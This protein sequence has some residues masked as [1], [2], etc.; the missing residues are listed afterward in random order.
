MKTP[1]WVPKLDPSETV[2]GAACAY[3]EAGWFVL[4]VDRG[5]KHAGSV[6]GRGWPEKSSRDSAVVRGWF[7]GT[8]YGV[9][10]HAGRSGCLAFDVDDPSALPPTLGEHLVAHTG[11]YQSTR[12]GSASR[13][14][15]LYLQPESRVHGNGRGLLQGTWGEVRGRNG[16][17]MAQPSPHSKPGGNYFWLR[18]GIVPRLP[19]ALDAALLGRSRARASRGSSRPRSVSARPAPGGQRRTPRT[20]AECVSSVLVSEQRNNAVF[21]SACRLGELVARGLVTRSRA[22]NTLLKAGRAVGLSDLELVG[23]D[24]QSGTIGSGLRTGAEA[25]RRRRPRA[26]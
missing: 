24:G 1:L 22:T 8:D 19:D 18:T 10:L 21:E 26:R 14:H 17:L 11:P 9:A 2:L 15:Y 4:P 3:A 20:P 23:H 16:I 6:L 12:Q 13:G 25:M 5:L 7:Q